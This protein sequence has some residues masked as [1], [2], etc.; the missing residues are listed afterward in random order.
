MLGQLEQ[1]A[2]SFSFH[3]LTIIW[4]NTLTRQSISHMHLL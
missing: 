1:S 2:K 4:L 3:E